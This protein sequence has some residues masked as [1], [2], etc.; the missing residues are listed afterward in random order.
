MGLLKIIVYF[1]YIINSVWFGRTF[2]SLLPGRLVY[3]SVLLSSSS[4]SLSFYQSMAWRP[5]V[6]FFKQC[7]SAR[8]RAKESI[9]SFS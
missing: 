8:L 6:V 2:W 4:E 9:P 7:P 3:I 1:Q 5:F